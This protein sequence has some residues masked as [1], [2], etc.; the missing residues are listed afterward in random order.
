MRKEKGQKI[1]RSRIWPQLPSDWGETNPY[2]NKKGEA[3]FHG[4]EGV[5]LGSILERGGE[6]VKKVQTFKQEH[7]TRL[8]IASN[9]GLR[10]GR[11]LREAKQ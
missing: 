7:L 10:V 4:E 6:V 2:L 5:Y 8:R 9:Q 11:D 3:L 1:Y